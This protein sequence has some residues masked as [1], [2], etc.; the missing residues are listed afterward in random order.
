MSFNIIKRDLSIT[1]RT[2][3]SMIPFQAVEARIGSYFA[4]AYMLSPGTPSR[5][6]KDILYLAH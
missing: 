2:V 1:Q 6:A 5:Q 4:F 3:G